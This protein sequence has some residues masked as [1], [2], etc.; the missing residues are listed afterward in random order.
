MIAYPY[1]YS[2]NGGDIDCIPTTI[3]ESEELTFYSASNNKFKIRKP[4]ESEAKLKVVDEIN[5]KTLNALTVSELRN[6]PNLQ[7][8]K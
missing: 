3:S 6:D 7:P 2:V 1:S 4:K 5:A 8:K